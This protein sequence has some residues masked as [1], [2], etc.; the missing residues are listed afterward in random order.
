MASYEERIEWRREEWYRYVSIWLICH[1]AR[2]ATGSS[3]VCDLRQDMQ[4]ETLNHRIVINRLFYPRNDFVLLERPSN[5]LTSVTC[6]RMHYQCVLLQQLLATILFVTC[7]FHSL[8]PSLHD[9]SQWPIFR[10][11]PLP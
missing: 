3:V 4:S 8:V 2:K 11:R 9:L 1:P 6:Q 10:I 7:C 5:T